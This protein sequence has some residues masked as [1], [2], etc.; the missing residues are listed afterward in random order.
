METDENSQDIP[1]A[2][3]A[4]DIVLRLLINKEGR[5]MTME[6]LKKSRDGK[7]KLVLSTFAVYEALQCVEFDEIDT[8]A[9]ALM[10]STVSVDPNIETAIKS[11]WFQPLSQE[12]ITHLR[13]AALGPEKTWK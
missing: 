11:E 13:S 6:M 2:Y 3:I 1:K 9:L 7:V 10:L 8:S 5:Q 12:R 4:P